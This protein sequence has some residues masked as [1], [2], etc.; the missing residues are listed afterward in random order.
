LIIG[1]PAVLRLPAVL[2]LLA[3]V[4]L[5]PEL[6]LLLVPGLFIV[7]RLALRLIL[8]LMLRLLPLCLPVLRLRLRPFGGRGLLPRLAARLRLRASVGGLLPGLLRGAP[9]VQRLGLAELRLGPGSLRRHGQ[10]GAALHVPRGGGGLLLHGEEL[11]PVF[12]RLHGRLLSMLN[13]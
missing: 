13:A 5:L 2:V 8:R 9:V 6:R 7:W 12:G 3:A 11:L 10:R 4:R 1:L